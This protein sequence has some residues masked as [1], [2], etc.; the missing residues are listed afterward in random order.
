MKINKLLKKLA[1]V[2]VVV[3]LGTSLVACGGNS[4]ANK[5]V[6]LKQKQVH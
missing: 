3:T 1:I 5:S 4:A 2:G 6:I